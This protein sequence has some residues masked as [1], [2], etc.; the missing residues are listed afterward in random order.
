MKPGKCYVI[1]VAWAN[2]VKRRAVIQTQ[3]PAV[4]SDSNPTMVRRCGT[5]ESPRRP[6]DRSRWINC[7]GRIAP[8]AYFVWGE[9][10]FPRR[11]IRCVDPIKAVD[12]PCCAG[13]RGERCRQVDLI[14][15]IG[16]RIRPGE[17][18]DKLDFR[19]FTN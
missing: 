5:G 4:R 6:L 15:V 13:R 11:I 7:L 1:G 12:F 19:V 10:D 14:R 2:A 17:P 8:G 16:V 3:I 9:P 18:D